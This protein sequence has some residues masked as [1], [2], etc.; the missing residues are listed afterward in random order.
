AVRESRDLRLTER[1]AKRGRDLLRKRPVG[2]AREKLQLIR[3]GFCHSFTSPTRAGPR[4]IR[5]VG[6]GG[7]EPP[8][9]GSK[10][11]RL[12]TWPRP[13]PPPPGARRRPPAPGPFPGLASPRRPPP[14][15]P[16]P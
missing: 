16:S 5:M 13:S 1:Q 14:P 2:I 11:P 9:T 15:S 12:T 3:H 6:A 7:F 4:L 10:V 8:N